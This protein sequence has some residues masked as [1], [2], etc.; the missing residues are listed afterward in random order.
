MYK[1]RLI[2]ATLL[3]ALSV[4]TLLRLTRGIATGGERICRHAIA[5][6]RTLPSGHAKPM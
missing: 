6:S 4:A 1:S 5:L 3:S 2:I